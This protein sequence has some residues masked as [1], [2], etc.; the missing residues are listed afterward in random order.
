MG[1]TLLAAKADFMDSVRSRV[2]HS[3]A[4]L[5]ALVAALIAYII[6]PGSQG[7]VPVFPSTLLGMVLLLGPLVGI[8]ISY[9]VLVAKRHTGELKVLLGLPFS[10]GELVLGSLLGRSLVLSVLTVTA[11]AAAFLVSLVTHGLPNLTSIL[12]VLL[13]GI[14]MSVVFVSVS[15][16][17]S[18]NS[19]TTSRAAG[20]A[21][22]V[23]LL[24]V[25]RVW[26]LL[27]TLVNTI[28]NQLSAPTIPQS[29]VD[30]YLQLTPHAGLR[31]LIQP[32]VPELAAGFQPFVSAPPTSP[33]LGLGVVLA[34][35][36]GPLL[37]GYLRFSRADLAT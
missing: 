31:N 29:A 7:G 1:R 22:L 37:L 5:F 18:A 10:R 34:W 8:Y 33:L 32:V 13:L 19:R 14:A 35:G 23:F 24:F 26:D 9:D 2:L 21:F 15:V 6:A 3:T 36:L 28:L 17:I 12:V 11:V 27:P 16:G 20:L 30:V 4:I 25:F